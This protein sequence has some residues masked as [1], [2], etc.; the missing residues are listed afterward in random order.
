MD[1]DDP[2]LRARP[3]RDRGWPMNVVQL[4][5]S[6]PVLGDRLTRALLVE[7]IGEELGLE[8][9]TEE[10]PTPM[11]EF[12]ELVRFCDARVGGLAALSN[13]VSRIEGDDSWLSGSLGELVRERIAQT[14]QTPAPAP[15]A[16]A[17]G[18][19]FSS[20][21]VSKPAAEGTA[22]QNGQ[23]SDG[24]RDFF[25]SYT[26]ADRRWAAWISWQLEDAGYSVLVQ[27]WD[28]VPGSNWQFGM[29][30]G[31][32]RCERTIAVLSPAYMRSVYG[33]QEWQAA[34]GKDP[35]GLT[36]NLVPV[37]VEPCSPEGLLAGVVHIDLT[38][39]SDGAA[40]RRRLLTGIGGARDG[41][42]K[43]TD[44]PPFPGSD[45]PR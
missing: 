21:A 18:P 10:Q 35:T 22:G 36:R 3:D 14:R 16:S 11:G 42:S 8:I 12:L 30:S 24:R 37:M 32:T 44:P 33:Q 6:S 17:S 1:K 38:N 20:S 5:L 43:P 23:H 7:L 31:V 28:F 19:D 29:E 41:R 26:G 25:V 4:L 15:S 39:C 2:K 40:V 13:A 45:D 27:E 34:Q 9:E